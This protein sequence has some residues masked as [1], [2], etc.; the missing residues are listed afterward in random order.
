MGKFE[1]TRHAFKN[2][3]KNRDKSIDQIVGK[4]MKKCLFRHF[5]LEQRTGK[6]ESQR[7]KLNERQCQNL[8]TISG[9]KIEN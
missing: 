6:K 8:V 9:A 4:S 3:D 2:I 1:S 5:S 7:Q